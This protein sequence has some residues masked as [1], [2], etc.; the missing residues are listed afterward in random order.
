MF[1]QL[2]DIY[3]VR[4]KQLW[5]EFRTRVAERKKGKKVFKALISRLVRLLFSRLSSLN[6][7][8]LVED[9]KTVKE[10]K[11]RLAMCK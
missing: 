11:V 1:L 8:Q 4:T 7:R 3:I 6:L 2:I 9:E 5:I 10:T